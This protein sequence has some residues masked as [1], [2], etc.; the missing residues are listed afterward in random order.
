MWGGVDGYAYCTKLHTLNNI[1][2]IL[3]CKVHAIQQSSSIIH[4]VILGHYYYINSATEIPGRKAQLVSQLFPATDPNQGRCLQFW[5][6]M[7]GTGIGVL[8]VYIYIHE[9]FINKMVL[10]WSNGGNEGNSWIQS[11]APIF[12]KGSY[13]VRILFI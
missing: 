1:N 10:I 2:F 11:Q 7:Y 9:R 6:H 5:R 8:N 4:F 3:S 13:Q 12:S